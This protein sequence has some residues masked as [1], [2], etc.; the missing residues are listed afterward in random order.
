MVH[1]S[2]STQTCVADVL[3]IVVLRV[4]ASKQELEIQELQAELDH[5]TLQLPTSL[6]HQETVFER[7]SRWIDRLRRLE[8]AH[9][10]ALAR[11]RAVAAAATATQLMEQ[12]EFLQQSIGEEL[13][14][15]IAWRESML[16]K[17]R[18]ELDALQ[19]QMRLQD[20]RA[21]KQHCQLTAERT[22]FQGERERASLVERSMVAVQDECRTQ[23]M[24]RG[25]LI[26]V[27]RLRSVEVE[28]RR[29]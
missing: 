20:D 9:E 15:I 28:V 5:C 3:D 7:D 4:A 2:C 11:T 23:A 8:H 18:E 14:A 1:N 13:T 22:A 25:E 21:S 10:Q 17:V 16:G 12:Q 6:L 29:N 24:C 19:E 26:E 27:D